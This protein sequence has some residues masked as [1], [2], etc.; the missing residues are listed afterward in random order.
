M[1]NT[2]SSFRR[3]NPLTDEWVLVSPQRNNR[4]WHGA[5]EAI[6]NDDLAQH[7]ANCPLCPGNQRAN[8]AVN[9]HFETT[10]VFNN[11]FAALAQ[12]RSDVSNHNDLFI[13]ESAV[14]E[15]RVMCFSPT[16]NR[17]LPRMSE[18]ALHAVVKTWCA[19]YK[20]L[21][22]RYCCV[23][24]FENKGEIMGCSQP[25][26]HGQIW[27]HEH[28]STEVEK[29]DRA[30]ANYFKKHGSAMLSDYAAREALNAKRVVLQNAHW[31]VVVPYWAKWPFETMLISLD[32]APD[33]THLTSASTLALAKTIKQLTSKYDNLFKCSFPYSMGWHNAPSQRTQLSHWVMHAHFYPPL[34]RSASVKK[35]MVGYE[36]LGESQRDLTPELAAQIL[37]DCPEQ[38]YL[39]NTSIS[40]CGE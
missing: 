14:G 18:D 22:Q 2:A 7:D 24:I 27:A 16:H 39:D 28:L 29:E 25:H 9:P 19:Q 26:P 35:H 10:F 21:S 17:S 11:D 34:L 33:F 4:P 13:Q 6:Q 40:K 15:A 37:R 8:G 31:L 23:Q 3:K 20:E 32:N 1:D 5:T 30:Q 36:M 12:T 38:H